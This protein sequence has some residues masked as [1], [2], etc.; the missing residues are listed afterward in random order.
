MY[1]KDI[2]DKLL[3]MASRALWDADNVK[4]P[5]YQEITGHAM[6]RF[7]QRAS[8]KGFDDKNILKCNVEISKVLNDEYKRDHYMGKTVDKFYGTTYWYRGC[9]KDG[10][11][12]YLILQTPTG[13]IKTVFNWSFDTDRVKFLK[14]RIIKLAEKLK[15]EYVRS[16]KSWK[17][18][19]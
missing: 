14:T 15:N 7:V 18:D 11:I 12:K 9:S 2:D 4:L 5:E 8:K 19:V 10:K 16:K 17:D 6:R 1:F 13:Y 3:I